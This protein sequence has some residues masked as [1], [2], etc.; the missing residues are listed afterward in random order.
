[1]IDYHNKIYLVETKSEGKKPRITQV[2]EFDRFKRV[3]V[4]VAVLDNKVSVDKF[5]KE[6]EDD[7]TMQSQMGGA[8]SRCNCKQ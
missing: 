2:R 5:I 3:G 4:L 8:E 6:I 1:M 7:K